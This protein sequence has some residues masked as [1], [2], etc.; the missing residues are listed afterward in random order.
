VAAGCVTQSGGPRVGEPQFRPFL[1][2]KKN[3]NE[4]EE[5]EEEEG[6]GGER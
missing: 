1:Q 5:K 6:G 3:K 2:N 4:E